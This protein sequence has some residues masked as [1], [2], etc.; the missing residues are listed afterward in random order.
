M[1]FPEYAWAQRLLVA[2]HSLVLAYEKD[3]KLSINDV[4]ESGRKAGFAPACT[5]T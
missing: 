1:R 4:G 5:Q 3:K 2:V